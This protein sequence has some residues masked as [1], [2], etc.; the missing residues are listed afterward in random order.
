[1][2]AEGSHGFI[3]GQQLI[4]SGI[5]SIDETVVDTAHDLGKSSA[6]RSQTH[7]VTV[8]FL[9]SESDPPTNA[10]DA[11]DGIDEAKDLFDIFNGHHLA[12]VVLLHPPG[13]NAAYD[14]PDQPR[15]LA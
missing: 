7:G 12:K 15:C 1:M 10:G 2:F 11:Y 14:T 9:F 8:T 13:H 3:P 6:V 4:F 5:G